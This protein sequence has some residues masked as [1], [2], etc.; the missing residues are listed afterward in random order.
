MENDKKDETTGGDPKEDETIEG[1]ANE[2]GS[3][4]TP[5]KRMCYNVLKISQ[6]VHAANATRSKYRRM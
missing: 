5:T 2:D 4:Q 3:Q 6:T 1:N